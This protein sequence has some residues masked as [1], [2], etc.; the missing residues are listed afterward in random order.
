VTISGSALAP[1]RD[2][3]R[4]QQTALAAGAL[5]VGAALLTRALR[6]ARTIDF[7]N[8]SVLITGGSRG[9]GLLVARELAAE[10]ARITLAARDQAE[11]DRARDDLAARGVD[12]RTIACDIAVPKDA[13]RLVD[14][15]ASRTGRI[16]VLINNAGIIQVGPLEH[17]TP[18]DF[19]EAMGV[20]FWGPLHT[21]LAAVP[22]MRAQGGGRIVNVSSIGGKIGVP[23]LAPYCAS[24]FAL[25]GL[26]DAVRGELAKDKIYVTTVIPGL[27]R[28][29]SPFNAW[30]KGRHRD[31]FTW[32]AISD[33]LPLAS[34][35]GRRAALQL[36]EACR[37]GDA[38]LVISW[39]AKI[40]VIANALMPEVVATLMSLVNE[41]ILP[42]PSPDAGEGRHSGWQSLSNWAP[43]RLTTLSERAAARNN[44]LPQ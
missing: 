43:S 9:L 3:N 25:T 17:M 27:M 32:F 40:G 15:V 1:S 31:E 5:T 24:K 34:I 22:M 2:M 30:F 23:H 41:L 16:D 4:T 37:H 12:V 21:T 29:G 19:E 7:T 28:T 8:R 35:D 39:P 20:H 10:G 36:I 44:E 13:A 42:A 38:E 18:G 26:S 6:A 11:L 14:E 33:S